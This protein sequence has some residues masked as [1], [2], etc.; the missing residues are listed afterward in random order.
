M[1]RIAHLEAA[2]GI[3]SI[4][5]VLH[6]FSWGFLPALMHSFTDGGLEKT[7]VFILLNGT[8][9]VAFFFLL[10]GFVLTYRFYLQFSAPDL[11]ASV[12][13]RLPRLMLPAGASMMIGAAILIW[14]PAYY[15]DAAKLTGSVWLETLGFAGISEGFA[16]S[17]QDALHSTFLVFIDTGH[18]QYNSN[19]WTMIF[20]FYGS[21]LVFILVAVSALLLHQ[22][23]YGVIAFHVVLL[24]LIF[25]AKAMWVDVMRYFPFV[26]GS[27]LAFLHSRY[28]ES[29]LL[30]RGRTTLA[31]LLMVMGYSMQ[32]W[33]ALNIASTAAMILLL[34]LP[35]LERR[36]SG[37][38][39][40]F[41]G[42]LSF[43]LYLVHVLV[44]FSATSAVW[45]ILSEYGLSLWM[46]AMLCL[47]LTCV[48]SLLAALPFMWLERH[49]VPAINRWTRTGLSKIWQR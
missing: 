46:V 22:M 35:S 37:P 1:K 14:L 28:P 21:L 48:L 16:P 39:G 2:R 6:H 36:L 27:L 19:L 33:L 44:M 34:S 25:L 40:L 17:F 31:F 15:I 20:E 49:W 8:G 24:L 23:R 9:A 42:R 5:V 18:T 47:A 13:K 4:I 43:P 10:S 38:F 32:N 12:I 45:I 30:T 29:F 11:I 7:P 26:V 3:A 41:L